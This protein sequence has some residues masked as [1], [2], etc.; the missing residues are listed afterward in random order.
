MVTH[1]YQ[2][3]ALLVPKLKITLKHIC[4][5]LKNGKKYVFLNKIKISFQYLEN[6]PLNVLKLIVDINLWI[7]TS[8]LNI[9]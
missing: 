1:K 7:E 9:F 8:F 2:E 5:Y 3:I 6:E 4:S